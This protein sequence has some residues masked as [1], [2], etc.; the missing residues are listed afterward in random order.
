MGAF[1]EIMSTQN[2][3]FQNGK[4]IESECT[5]LPLCDN[6]SDC[7][8]LT[9]DDSYNYQAVLSNLNELSGFSFTA[10]DFSHDI[11]IGLSKH[12]VHEDKKWEI[13]LGGWKG[14][15]TVIRNNNQS[16]KNGLVRREHTVEEFDAWKT[17]GITVKINNGS[18][19]ILDAE[20]DIILEYKDEA[21]VEDELRFVLISGGFAGSGTIAKITPISNWQFNEGNCWHECNRTAGQ[22]DACNQGDVT[23]YCC[24]PGWGDNRDCPNDAILSISPFKDRH[25]CFFQP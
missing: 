24:R 10:P 13:V 19:K 15:K 20:E 22:C 23:G 6:K 18:I 5:V 1:S 16:P 3:K 12:D 11:H 17:Y 14:T 2:V 9:F 21:I 7:T 4:V 8:D 25:H